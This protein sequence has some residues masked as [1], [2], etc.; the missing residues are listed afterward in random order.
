[1]QEK[2]YF[3]IKLEIGK[4]GGSHIF[5]WLSSTFGIHTPLSFLAELKNSQKPGFKQ[6][7][8]EY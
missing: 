2:F 4:T 8:V 3:Y 7:N 6:L 1:L 5:I